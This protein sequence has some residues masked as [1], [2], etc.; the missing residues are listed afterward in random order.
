MLACL[1]ARSLA[2]ANGPKLLHYCAHVSRAWH[3]DET[4]RCSVCG[5]V[6]RQGEK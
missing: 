3:S 5:R 4:N 2:F 1:F 6:N